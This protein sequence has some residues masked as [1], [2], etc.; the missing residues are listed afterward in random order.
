MGVE[1]YEMR[2]DPDAADAG[3]AGSGSSNGSGSSIRSLGAFGSSDSQ[4][5]GSSRSMLHS[6]LLTIDGRLI[7]V[8]S[9]NLDL[10]SQLQNTELA[11]LI[12]SDELSRV[13]NGHIEE[14][15]RAGTWRVEKV[16]GSLIW[17]APQGSGLQDSTTEP[18]TT[19]RQRLM[20]RVI[21]PLAPDRLL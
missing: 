1:L 13:A 4:I 20:I 11:L 2:S 8:G 12:R 10:R 21:S 3:L 16:D 17:R 18:Q 7:V 6:K 14:A 9:M 19:L 5:G 15:F